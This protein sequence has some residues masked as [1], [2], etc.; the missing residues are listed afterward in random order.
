M[1][2]RGTKVRASPVKGPGPGDALAV[3][4]SPIVSTFGWQWEDR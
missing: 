1:A 2:A 4:G 3:E